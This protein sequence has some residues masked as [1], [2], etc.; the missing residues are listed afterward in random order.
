MQS[1]DRKR[2]RKCWSGHRVSIGDLVIK[3]VSGADAKPPSG[4]K[5]GQQNRARDDERRGQ[6][7]MIDANQARSEGC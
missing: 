4:S 3:N 2:H 7:L 5:R 6:A 1:V